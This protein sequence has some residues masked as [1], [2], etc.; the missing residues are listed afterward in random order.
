MNVSGIPAPKPKVVIA[1]DYPAMLD[2]VARLLARDFNLISRVADGAAAVEAALALNPDILI[3]DIAMPRMDGFEAAKRLQEAGCS[4]KIIFLTAGDEQGGLD[5]RGIGVQGYV[6]KRRMR[7][8]LVFAIKEVLAGR[9]FFRD[10][11]I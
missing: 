1:D 4:T 9:L 10:D 7:S 2:K 5:W 11:S 6:L 8:D 3:L